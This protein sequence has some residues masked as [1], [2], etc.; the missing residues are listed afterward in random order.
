M[1]IELPR[2]PMRLILKYHVHYV[3]IVEFI[4]SQSNKRYFVIS[5]QFKNIIFRDLSEQWLKST[6]FL[7]RLE[8]GWHCP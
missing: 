3:I 4:P 1:V 7:L 5:M 6:V 2:V 8:G